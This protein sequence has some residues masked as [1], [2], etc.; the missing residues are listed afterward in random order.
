MLLPIQLIITGEINAAEV[1]E[2]E[3]EAVVEVE[4]AEEAEVTSEAVAEVN[5]IPRDQYHQIN[6]YGA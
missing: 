5:A 3:V 6:A 2:V 1:P 4:V